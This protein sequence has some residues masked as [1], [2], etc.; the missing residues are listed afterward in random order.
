[1]ILREWRAWV[2]RERSGEYPSYFRNHVVPDLRRVPG[3]LGALLNERPKDDVVEFLVLTRWTSMDAVHAFT[4][5][6]SD[7]AV[8]EPGAVAVLTD[9]E[10]FVR[11]YEVLAAVSAE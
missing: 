5:P 10:C 2:N 9:Y 1:M 4:G 3:F 7:E 11:H 8:V 6:N